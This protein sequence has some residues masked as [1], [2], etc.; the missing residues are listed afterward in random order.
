VLTAA[1]VAGK[2]D[3]ESQKRLG[4]CCGIKSGHLSDPQG[5]VGELGGDASSPSS[6][7]IIMT[8]RPSEI[9]ELRQT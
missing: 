1:S 2:P 9:G 5:A 7:C 3:W 4:Q 8:A 6:A